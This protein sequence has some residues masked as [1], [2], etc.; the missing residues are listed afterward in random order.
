[1]PDSLAIVVLLIVDDILVA[2][3]ERIFDSPVRF[4]RAALGIEND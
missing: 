1:M 2:C 3:A 4:M